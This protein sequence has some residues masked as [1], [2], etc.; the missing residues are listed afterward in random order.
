MPCNHR[1][2][3]ADS[4]RARA[5]H[6]TARFH[7][8]GVDAP[9]LLYLC[10][11]PRGLRP[12]ARLDDPTR[13]GTTDTAARDRSRA[14]ARRGDGV[15]RLLAGDA[16]R[17]GH[18]LGLC[19]RGALELLHD[20]A[21]PRVREGQLPAGHRDRARRP[22]LGAR[23]PDDE[24]RCE[25]RRGG[26]RWRALRI[27]WRP[28]PRGPRRHHAAHPA[29]RA[30]LGARLVAWRRSARLSV[31]RAAPHAVS[32]RCRAPL[33]RRGAGPQRDPS[34]WH[35]ARDRSVDRSGRYHDLAVHHA[36]AHAAAL[37]DRRRRGADLCR[38]HRDH[39]APRSAARSRGS[40]AWRTRSRSPR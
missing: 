22:R 4:D 18:A 28:S 35:S 39:L 14:P 36:R 21:R 8:H 6:T 31:V 1:R 26:D 23:G 27:R 15:G 29:H 9:S 32:A 16:G 30:R 17:S 11:R 12:A 2:G 7:D 24:R 19:R 20:R 25:L 5:F 34:P 3:P 40:R 10:A 38:A 37:R 33:A 13:R